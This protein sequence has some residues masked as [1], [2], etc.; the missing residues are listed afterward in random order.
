MSHDLILGS[1]NRNF[2]LGLEAPKLGPALPVSDEVTVTFSPEEKS[3]LEKV[4]ILRMKA[5]SGDKDAKKQLVSFTK[6]VAKLKAQA[7]KG[8]DK[9]KRALLVLRESGIFNP[10]QQITILGAFINQ[11]RREARHNRR[12]QKI[13]NLKTRAASG[14]Q[15]AIARLQRMQQ[16][17][18]SA[19]PTGITPL[20]GTSSY[21][22]VNP[23]TSQ[24][25]YATQ[26]AYVPQ[27]SYAAQPAYAPP[28]YQD[29][30][31]NYYQTQPQPGVVPPT[32]DVFVGHRS[33]RRD[34]EMAAEREDRGIVG[35][36]FVGGNAIPHENYRVAVMKAAVKSANGTKPS[37]KDFFKAKAAVDKVIGKSGITIYMP[38]AQPGRRTI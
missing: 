29:A 16:Q 27:P 18:N 17:L 6:N 5:D 26:P 3:M 33:R 34:E 30:D 2:S 38:G 37:T 28:Y 32:V 22:P 1:T 31:G 35:G 9:A 8:D 15:R 25:A 13:A 20:P 24:P 19:T 21:Q 14:D 12:S 10:T 36:S 11:G 4:S 23:G 7:G